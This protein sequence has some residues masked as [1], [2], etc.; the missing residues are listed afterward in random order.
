MALISLLG[1]WREEDEVFKASVRYTA[2]WKP[3]EIL[4]QEKKKVILAY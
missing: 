4:S 1:E 2:S 3:H